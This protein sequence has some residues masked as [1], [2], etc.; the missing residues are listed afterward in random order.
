MGGQSKWS[1]YCQWG[2][3]SMWSTYVQWSGYYKWSVYSFKG[4]NSPINGQPVA[5]VVE[6]VNGQLELW[7]NWST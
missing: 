3:Q 1:A 7:S 6:R 2:G 5:R 4:G